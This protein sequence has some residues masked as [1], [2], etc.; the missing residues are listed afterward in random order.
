MIGKVI[1]LGLVWLLYPYAMVPYIYESIHPIKL[2]VIHLLKKDMSEPGTR[3]CSNAW[4]YL[5]DEHGGSPQKRLTFDTQQPIDARDRSRWWTDRCRLSYPLPPPPHFCKSGASAPWFHFDSKFRCNIFG[6]GSLP[7]E[8]G[9]V[10]CLKYK[11]TRSS[12]T[13]NPVSHRWSNPGGWGIR[14]NWDPRI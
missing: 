2:Q 1:W 6:L 12:M 4:W 8:S 10:C 14:K 9:A 5:G 7:L 13:R 3:D 11:G